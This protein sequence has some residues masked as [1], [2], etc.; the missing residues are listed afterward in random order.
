MSTIF[1]SSTL[2]AHCLNTSNQNPH[3]MTLLLP[4]SPLKTWAPYLCGPPSI[5]TSVAIMTATIVVP[6]LF[7]P[8]VANT[9][10]GF[11]KACLIL[12][13]HRQNG[14]TKKLAICGSIA[15]FLFALAQS[16]PNPALIVISACVGWYSGR[17]LTLKTQ[18]VS[19][20]A[21]GFNKDL[22]NLKTAVEL[23]KKSD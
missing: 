10:A 6:Q 23:Q 14:E 8:Q 2:T 18:L 3:T 5:S 11:A 1:F 4:N 13:R 7:I 21:E 9:R 17:A 22:R 15:A 20:I 16:G 12:V 19:C